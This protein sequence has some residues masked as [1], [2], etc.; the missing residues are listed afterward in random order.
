MLIIK[1]RDFII[2]V[3]SFPSFALPSRFS[4]E[5][6]EVRYVSKRGGGGLQKNVH[7]TF[8]MDKID[9]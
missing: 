2:F 6:K 5:S 4:A 1:S 8:L 9:M 3:C 7:M